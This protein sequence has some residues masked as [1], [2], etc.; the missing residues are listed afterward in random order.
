MRR[1]TPLL[2]LALVWAPAALAAKPKADLEVVASAPGVVAIGDDL[3]ARATVRN[4][5]PASSNAVRLTVTLSGPF[6]L[7][8]ADSSRGSCSVTGAVVT[9]NLGKLSRGPTVAVDLELNATAAGDLRGAF[10]VR[11]QR[12]DPAPRNNSARTLTSVP[13]ADCT[14]LGTAGRDRLQGTPGHDVICGLGGNDILIGSTGNDKLYGGAGNDKLDGGLG[15]DDL[16]G[17]DGAD[18]VTYKKSAARVVADLARGNARGQGSDSLA[19]LERLVGSR[20]RDT[21]RGSRAANILTGGAGS[22]RMLGLRGA[23][24]LR[25]NAGNDYLS[26]GPGSDR[27]YGSAG[28]DRCLSGLRFSC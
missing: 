2:V 19:S 26:G 10:S 14:L 12:S 9:C 18:T 24:K 13:R 8:S 21:L 4:R 17:E 1:F 7:L 15:D 28:R 3:T 25:G 6:A 23:D 5:G 11:G 27:L 16:R 20:Y 22:D